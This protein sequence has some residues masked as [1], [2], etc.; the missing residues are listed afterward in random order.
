MFQLNLLGFIPIKKNQTCNELFY[1]VHIAMRP[2]YISIFPLSNAFL[3]VFLLVY[4]SICM[5]HIN[6]IK[7]NH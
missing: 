6:K 7:K 4:K 5:T 3:T 1:R 2:Y